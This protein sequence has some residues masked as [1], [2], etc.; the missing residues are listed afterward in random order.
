MKVPSNSGKKIIGA[1]SAG[2]RQDKLKAEKYR[3]ELNSLKDYALTAAEADRGED[4]R[5][6]PHEIQET[7]NWLKNEFAE[8]PTQKRIIAR[9]E[10]EV[11]HG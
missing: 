10:R 5:A 3:G 11:N 1:S 4:I 6:D 8:T 9:L 7:I 2:F